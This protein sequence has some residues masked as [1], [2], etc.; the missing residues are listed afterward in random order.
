MATARTGPPTGGR[1]FAVGG[2]VYSGSTSSAAYALPGCVVLFHVESFAMVVNGF[3]ASGCTHHWPARA[4]NTIRCCGRAPLTR[5][6]M[7]FT[8][9]ALPSPAAG[10]VVKSIDGR[11]EG[12]EFWQA[13]IA[14]HTT[15]TLP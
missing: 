7:A 6:S 8:M 10:S 4:N 2:G 5:P 13:H 9:S 1:A 3:A 15:A 14:R 12:R 11:G